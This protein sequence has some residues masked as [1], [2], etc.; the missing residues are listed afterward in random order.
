MTAALPSLA[1]PKPNPDWVW[2]PLFDR[3]GWKRVLF[4]DVVENCAETGRKMEG[5]KKGTTNGVQRR[6]GGGGAEGAIVGLCAL[7]WGCC[8]PLG[9]GCWGALIP[10]RCPG[11]ACW[12]PLGLGEGGGAAGEGRWGRV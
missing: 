7:R 11:L 6:G 8:A 4:G 2:L 3:T 12:A 10:G 5:R 9:L 1:K